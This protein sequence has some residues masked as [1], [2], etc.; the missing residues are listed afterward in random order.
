MMEFIRVKY[1]SY[2]ELCMVELTEEELK[3]EEKHFYGE[4]T[5]G[6][7]YDKLDPSAVLAFLAQKKTKV[8]K[9]PK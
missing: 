6:F 7:I 8:F 9:M 1:P 4:Y 3:D 5:C 2:F